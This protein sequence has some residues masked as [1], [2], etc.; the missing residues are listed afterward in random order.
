LIVFR[1]ERPAVLIGTSSVR[2]CHMTTLKPVHNFAG[3]GT[4]SAPRLAGT[5]SW[6]TDFNLRTGSA[7]LLQGG[8]RTCT[9]VFWRILDRAADS[10]LARM[11]RAFL[12][13]AAPLDTQQ[14]AAATPLFCERAA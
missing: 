1:Y 5:E 9:A 12:L 10:L 3:I 14:S 4:G 6:S 11:R 8:S 2:L 7:A 13:R